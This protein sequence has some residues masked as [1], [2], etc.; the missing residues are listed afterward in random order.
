MGHLGNPIAFR[1]NYSKKWAD[2]WFVKNLYYPEFLNKM[3]N[4]RDYLYYFFTKKSMLKSGNCLSHLNI[5]KIQKLYVIKIYI[6]SIDL[7]KLSYDFIN[8]IYN[9]Y[10]STL[11]TYTGKISGVTKDILK[12]KLSKKRLINELQNS[13]LFAFIFIYY[14]FELFVKKNNNTYLQHNAVLKSKNLLYSD[15]LLNRYMNYIFFKL[16]FSSVRKTSK[17][18]FSSFVKKRKLLKCFKK[19]EQKK[20]R[21]LI[22][23]FYKLKNNW[24][25]KINKINI[26]RI[27]KSLKPLKIKAFKKTI[28]KDEQSYLDY[29][30]NTLTH[31]KFWKK[32]KLFISGFK[33]KK[34]K[35]QDLNNKIYIT[36]NDTIWYKQKLNFFDFFFFLLKKMKFEKFNNTFNLYNKWSRARV[37]FNPLKKVFNIKNKTAFY[38]LLQAFIS[39]NKM[40]STLK[41]KKNF[42][43][44]IY[45]SL[46]NLLGKFFFF[47][48]LK[49]VI[50]Y[51]K[52]IL[53]LVNSNINVKKISFIFHF[54]S[55]LNVTAHLISFYLAMKFKKGFTLFGATNPLRFELARLHFKNKQ[56]KYPY[57]L[58]NYKALFH[59]KVRRYKA[60]LTKTL[61][62]LKLLVKNILYVNY[63]NNNSLIIYNTFIYNKNFKYKIFKDFTK[64]FYISI[65]YRVFITFNKIVLKSKIYFNILFLNAFD[66]LNYMSYF[67]KYKRKL[68]VKL[69]NFSLYFYKNILN[70]EYLKK[71]WWKFNNFNLRN[72]RQTYIVKYKSILMGFK[73]AFRGRFSRKQRASFIWI[74]EGKVPLNTLNL[75]IDYSFLTISLKNSAVSIKIWLYRNIMYS[76]FKYILK[77]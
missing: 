61:K 46:Y 30:K 77:I 5:I 21:N 53:N 4:V 73:F 25:K 12:K 13:D 68:P 24:V 17:R 9:L 15:K 51:V 67:I 56:N 34:F 27:K 54:M 39:L 18:L 48:P 45:F 14:F 65:F 59:K 52:Y 31:Q 22:W 42:R 76:A 11:K 16:K 36:S 38:F 49:L 50:N 58:H 2:T 29:F 74:H 72:I 55:N 70:Y 66:T 60:V 26:L 23:G 43:D 3:L 63:L 75:F 44:G 71:L 57:T 40:V 47:R 41:Y 35:T 28:T 37:F 62:Y 1:L 7:E 69:I 32:N 64:L 8:K 33:I 6:Y 20:K 10:Y 19:I